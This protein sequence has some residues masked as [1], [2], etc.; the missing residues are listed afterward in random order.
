MSDPT[1]FDSGLIHEWFKPERARMRMRTEGECRELLGIA[2]VQET[3]SR[4][5][6]YWHGV[7]DGLQYA[8]GGMPDPIRAWLTARHAQRWQAGEE[9]HK[10]EDTEDDYCPRCSHPWGYHGSAAGCSMPL[11]KTGEPATRG[12]VADHACHCTG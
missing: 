1:Q 2:A 3:T 9:T 8:L 7:S 10:G 5:L 12:E 6:D 11:T 4:A